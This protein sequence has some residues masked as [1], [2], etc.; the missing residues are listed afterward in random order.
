MGVFRVS[1]RL[2]YR[3]LRADGGFYAPS[4]HR[5]ISVPDSDVE[6]RF[7]DWGGCSSVPSV[8]PPSIGIELSSVFRTNP[9]RMGVFR[10]LRVSVSVSKS[11]RRF[12]RSRLCIEIFRS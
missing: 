9:A 3:S 11:E 8:S 1:A 10:V 4:L 12:L 6:D 5:K 2:L 7:D